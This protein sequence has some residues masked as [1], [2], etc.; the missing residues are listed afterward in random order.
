MFFFRRTYTNLKW[1][2]QMT[3]HVVLETKKTYIVRKTSSFHDNVFSQQHL[4]PCNEIH[5]WKQNNLSIGTSK[6]IKL[7]NEANNSKFAARK[8]NIAND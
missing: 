6:N 3:R 1:R 8:W 5:K 2:H 4:I 7:L